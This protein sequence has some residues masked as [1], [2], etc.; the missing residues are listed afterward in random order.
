MAG[1]GLAQQRTLGYLLNALAVSGLLMVPH[2]YGGVVNARH[3]TAGK[4]K[5][6]LRFAFSLA[7]SKTARGHFAFGIYFIERPFLC[8]DGIFWLGA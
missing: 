1:D 4:P 5:A 7:S 6:G 3:T 2:G 8:G